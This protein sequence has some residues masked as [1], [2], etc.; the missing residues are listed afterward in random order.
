MNAGMSAEKTGIKAEE[1]II[2]DPGQAPELQNKPEM[3]TNVGD[4]YSEHYSSARRRKIGSFGN[5]IFLQLIFSAVISFGLWAGNTF[6]GEE[7]RSVCTS[8][9]L[10]F[11]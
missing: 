5:I 7:I 3:Y 9:I 11:A 8:L 4:V 6:G 2:S 10:L 1:P